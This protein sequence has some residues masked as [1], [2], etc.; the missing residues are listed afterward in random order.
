MKKKKEQAFP[1]VI[2]IYPDRRQ[3]RRDREIKL[4][5]KAAPDDWRRL[6]EF[7]KD[8]PD[9]FQYEFSCEIT[10]ILS[11]LPPPSYK[12]NTFEAGFCSA[13]RNDRKPRGNHKKN[14]WLENQINSGAGKLYSLFSCY[15]KNQN[16]QPAFFKKLKD[17]VKKNGYISTGYSD[18]FLLTGLVIYCIE[19]TYGGRLKSWG[20]KKIDKNKHN[21]FYNIYIVNNDY[22]KF[23]KKHPVISDANDILKG[24]APFLTRASFFQKF[25]KITP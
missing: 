16:E 14:A 2:R 9:G 18:K 4:K 20:M 8:N 13:C 22:I 23:Y 25:Q 11:N 10:N 19:K 15:H 21:S 3:D 7:I 12:K 24:H 1:A 5:V 6:A 17:I